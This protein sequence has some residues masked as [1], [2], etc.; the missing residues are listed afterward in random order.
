MFLLSFI[1]HNHSDPSLTLTHVT[2]VLPFSHSGDTSCRTA[3]EFLIFVLVVGYVVRV[4]T[5]TPGVPELLKR[6][7]GI[8]VV[9]VGVLGPPLRRGLRWVSTRLFAQT[10]VPHHHHP[11]RPGRVGI[12]PSSSTVSEVVPPKTPV[13]RPTLFG[14]CFP[15]VSV[16]RDSSRLRCLCVTLSPTVPNLAPLKH[17]LPLSP[18]PP[19]D[20]FKTST[21]TNTDVLYTGTEDGAVTCE[22]SPVPGRV[23]E[24]GL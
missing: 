13:A 10:G 24:C 21:Y 4:E 2:P 23:A 18:S 17:D 3:K 12:V 14:P 9:V 6:H 11:P 20:C 5:P 15:V 8:S 1:G 16:L 22:F 19:F 7:V